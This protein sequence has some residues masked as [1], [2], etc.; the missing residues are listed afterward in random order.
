MKLFLLMALFFH[1]GSFMLSMFRSSL[2]LTIPDILNF[3]QNFDHFW[4]AVPF[5][6]PLKHKKKTDMVS[7][8]LYSS[9]N[10]DID[11]SDALFCK[12]RFNQGR[13][14]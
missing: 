6:K 8:V 5:P 10:S 9:V 13:V 7:M 12:Y 2:L 3:Q 1:F 14:A 11:F 4:E